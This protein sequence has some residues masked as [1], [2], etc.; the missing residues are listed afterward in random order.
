MFVL[1]TDVGDI[2]I[3]QPSH[4]YSPTAPEQVTPY[5]LPQGYPATA[6]ST[7]EADEHFIAPKSLLPKLFTTLSARYAER[8][9]GYTR[10]QRYGNRQGDNAPLAILSLVDGPRDLKFEMAART[11]G[12][13]TVKRGM[14]RGEG[15]VPSIGF[16]G[17][18]EY[19]LRSAEK[20]LKYRGDEGRKE[21]EDVAKQ[22]A[23]SLL[24]ESDALNGLRRPST[25]KTAKPFKAA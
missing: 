7:L 3:P 11:V 5:P 16:V 17:L 25:V 4:H 19:T 10:L 22:F 18:R 24:L 1:I 8:P 13:E 6:S 23:N 9:G 15:S 21:F 12:F 20:V 14:Q 2:L